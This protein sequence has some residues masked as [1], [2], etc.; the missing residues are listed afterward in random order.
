MSS[1][2]KKS[3]RIFVKECLS[4]ALIIVFLCEIIF[5]ASR[6]PSSYGA[7]TIGK[8]RRLENAPQPRLILVGGSGI[9]FGLDSN[10]LKKETSLNPV[11]LGLY[12]GF[13]IDFMLAQASSGAK[14]GDLIILIPEFDILDSVPSATGFISLEAL[15]QDPQLTPFVFSNPKSSISLLRQFPGWLSTRVYSL[16]GKY[17]VDPIKPREETLYRRVY[18]ASNF[19]EYGDMVGHLSE[20]YL[21]PVSEITATSTAFSDIPNT[22]TIAHIDAF[23][24]AEEKK[25]VTVLFSWPALPK[26]V[27]RNNESNLLKQEEYIVNQLGTEKILGRQKDFIFD[28]GQFFDS[29]GHLTADGR[30]IRTARLAQLLRAPLELERTND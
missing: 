30:E 26:T 3:V 24:L 12:A 4:I 8:M 5:V 23:I 9:A 18:K 22:E 2:E 17:V 15:Q 11:N 7:A 13:G 21:L 27:Y 14:T 28:D 16:I 29:I 25:G 1:T 19:N 20:S 10:T 6:D